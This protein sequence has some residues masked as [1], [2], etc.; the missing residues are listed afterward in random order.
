[1]ALKGIVFVNAP[2]DFNSKQINALHETVLKQ[3]GNPKDVS[4]VVAPGNA[5]FQALDHAYTQEKKD[6]SAA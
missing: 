3:L 2:D 5:Y 6:D 4:V 1:M